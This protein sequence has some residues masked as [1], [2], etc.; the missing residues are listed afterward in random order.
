MIHPY[1]SE[2]TVVIKG[3]DEYVI[4]EPPALYFIYLFIYLKKIFFPLSDL[5]TY[6]PAG[7]P[8]IL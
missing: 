2:E 5:N 6:G 7:F 4:S 3:F 1:H 8:L